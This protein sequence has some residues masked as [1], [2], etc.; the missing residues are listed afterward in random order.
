MKERL[1]SE[2]RKIIAKYHHLRMATKNVHVYFIIS[3]YVS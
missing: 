2:C 3:S 1:P